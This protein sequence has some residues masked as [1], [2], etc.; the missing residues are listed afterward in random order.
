MRPDPRQHPERDES[1][2]II[3]LGDVR[4][5]RGSRRQEP[6]THYLAALVLV[7]VACLA[8]WAAV[9]LTLQPARLLTY[10]A[11]F[12]PLG[13]ALAALATIGVY[14]L[15]WR[16]GLFPSLSRCVRRGALIAVVIVAN[17]AVRAGHRWTLLIALGSV[18]VALLVD[19]VA[20]RRDE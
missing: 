8:I 4:R 15:E 20:A 7:A 12:V 10:L 16:R 2:R 17:L 14:A 5:R 1:G 19:A 13:I 9:L 6:D 18:A 11:F 3:Y